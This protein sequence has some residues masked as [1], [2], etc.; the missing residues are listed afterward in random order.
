MKI[1]NAIQ[2]YLNRNCGIIMNVDNAVYKNE[3]GKLIIEI[4]KESFEK[5]SYILVAESETSTFSTVEGDIYKGKAVGLINQKGDGF[6][7]CDKHL[8]LIKK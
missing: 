7:I 2:S 5:Y 3:N 6:T 4:P 8:K 1:I